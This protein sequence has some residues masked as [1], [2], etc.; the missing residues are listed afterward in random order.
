MGRY[1]AEKPK[2]NANA[3]FNPH[4]SEPFLRDEFIAIRDDIDGPFYVARIMDVREQNVL[5]HYYG[6]TEIVL[7]SAIFKPCWHEVGDDTI[8]LYFASPASV[9]ERFAPY[10]GE[11][12]LNDM[13]HVLIARHLDFTKAGKLRFRAL[14]ALAPVHDQLFRFTR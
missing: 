1:Y 6:C 14:R 13:K 10:T 12:D 7:A 9:D 2:A 4:Y 11:V 8:V 5:L 3:S